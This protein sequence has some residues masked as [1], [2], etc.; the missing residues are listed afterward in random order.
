[1]KI[2]EVFTEPE[3]IQ[4]GS[5]FIIKVKVKDGL[6]YAEL[7]TLSYADIKNNLSYEEVKGD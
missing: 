4:T 1:M 5:S 7:K 6:T 3:I 2:K